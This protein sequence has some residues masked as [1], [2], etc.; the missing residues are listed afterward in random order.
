MRRFEA[1]CLVIER[2]HLILL[3]GLCYDSAHLREVW[4]SVG[5]VLINLPYVLSM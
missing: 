1:F 5:H 2:G 4:W 3:V